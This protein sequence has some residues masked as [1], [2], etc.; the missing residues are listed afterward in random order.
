MGIVY[1]GH[2]LKHDRQ[3]A[4]KVMRPELVASLGSERFLREIQIEARFQHP[5]IVPLYDSGQADGFLSFVMPYIEGE[6]LRARIRRE[7]Q[8]PVE[9]ALQIAREVGAALTYAHSHDVMHR[10]I[11][12]EN[13]LLSAGEAMVADFGIARAISA[14]G[15]A[16][17]T[18]TGISVGTPGYCQL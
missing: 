2:D 8:L 14:A 15:G 4:V 10:D 6:T 18:G 7:G 9:D 1:L 13:I 3:V 5:H 12:P 11:K 16:Q 17:L